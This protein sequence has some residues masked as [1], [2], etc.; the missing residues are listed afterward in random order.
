M[1]AIIRVIINFFKK[2][3]G[4]E[5]KPIENENPQVNPSTEGSGTTEDNNTQ[6]ENVETSTTVS[7]S[8]SILDTITD[9]DSA[10]TEYDDSQ[11]E[12]TYPSFKVVE[13]DNSI[14]GAV[15]SSQ[16]IDGNGEIIITR[17]EYNYD[18]K[19]LTVTSKRVTEGSEPPF[20]I[21]G[22]EFDV[23]IDKDKVTKGNT[24]PNQ[25]IEF[26]ATIGGNKISSSFTV[27]NDCCFDYPVNERP[28]AKPYFEDNSNK[29]YV[30]VGLSILKNG[31]TPA[32][33]PNSGKAEFDYTIKWFVPN[34][35]NK[36]THMETSGHFKGNHTDMVTVERPVC[37]GQPM[38]VE[39]FTTTVP[40]GN[41]KGRDCVNYLYKSY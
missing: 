31:K 1:K 17:P 36:C 22:W 35:P 23:Q 14:C 5:D 18:S 19:I 26:V 27:G 6:Q 16:T 39:S 38:E 41:L 33:K 4:I 10:N 13:I 21:L 11:D 7:S 2:L 34:K 9:Y 30:S 20:K 12:V 8:G 15:Y 25:T 29:N 40:K 32:I 28:I 24:V 37:Q 3:F